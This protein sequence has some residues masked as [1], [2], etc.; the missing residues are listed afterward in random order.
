MIAAALPFVVLVGAGAGLAHALGA[1][2]ASA[3]AFHA[4]LGKSVPGFTLPSAIDGKQVQAEAPDSRATVIMFISTNCPVSNA[5]NG[6]IERLAQT[7]GP[8][9]VRFVGINS[10]ANESPDEIASHAKDHGF[11]FVVLKDSDDAIADDFNAQHT[12]EV[13]VLD[14]RGVARYHGAID[15]NRSEQGVKSHYLADAL[16]AVLAGKTPARA[17]TIAF[18]CGIHRR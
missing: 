1:S 7:Y 14:S 3:P 16:D 5:Y 13:W 15:D 10:N 6:R 11:T 8:K 17:Q 12:P 4:Q 2:G 9:G 18:G